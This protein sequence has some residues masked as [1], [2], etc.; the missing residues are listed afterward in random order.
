MEL[1]FRKQNTM[2]KSRINYNQN[3]K[4]YAREN[5]KNPTKSETLVWNMILKN[6]RLW[7]KF[8][9][10]RTIWN[11]I[12]DFYCKELKLVIEIDGES[13]NYKSNYDSKRKSYLQNLWLKVL[14]Y[15]D[16]QVLNNLKWVFEDIK[17]NIEQNITPNYSDKSERT[18]SP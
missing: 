8:M 16:E 7:V 10:Q 13:H 18:T 9:R 12:V 2:K 17:Y 4:N 6:N 15:T 11:Y 1:K 14:V 3:N 5:R